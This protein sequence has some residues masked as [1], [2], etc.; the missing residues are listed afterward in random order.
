MTYNKAELEEQLSAVED[1]EGSGEI[2]EIEEKTA[3]ELFGDKAKSDKDREMIRLTVQ[4]TV[5]DEVEE[6]TETFSLPK[7]NFSWANED[8][9]LRRFREEYGELPEEGMIVKVKLNSD[10]YPRIVK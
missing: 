7:G 5:A 3:G 6:F 8:F 9:K 1:F 2:T 10:G 4:T